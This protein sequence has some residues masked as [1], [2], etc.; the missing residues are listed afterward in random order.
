MTD[1]GRVSEETKG[2]TLGERNEAEI[3]ELPYAP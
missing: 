2:V 1:F 3:F